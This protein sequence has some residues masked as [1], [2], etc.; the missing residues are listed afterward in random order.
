M[1]CRLVHFCT[2]DCILILNAISSCTLLYGWLPSHF[3]WILVI[4]ISV[5]MTTFSF[6][7]DFRPVHFCT[8]D[9]HF[10]LSGLSSFT[11]LYGWLPSHFEWIVVI[12]ISVRMTTISFWMDFRHVH[13]CTNDYHLILNGL[14]SCTFLYKWLPF[15]LEWIVVMHVSV[16]MTT[17]YFRMDFR[18]ARS[19]QMTLH[20]LYMDFR[21]AH[22]YWF[23]HVCSA[24]QRV[25]STVQ[26]RIINNIIMYL[27]FRP[28]A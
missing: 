20:T 23:F 18:H 27:G 24:L 1:E 22:F 11:F 6:W 7:V 2:D 14:L 13:F 9:Y 10:F 3:E 15:L 26:W 19:V 21:H 8:N 17:I 28:C 12:Y 5:R 25:N 16:R 4:Y